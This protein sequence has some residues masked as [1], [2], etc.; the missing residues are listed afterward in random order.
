MVPE[1]LELPPTRAF[2]YHGFLDFAGGSG[3]DSATLAIAHKQGN[4]SGI[5]VLDAVR[6][7]RPPFSPE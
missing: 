3:G 4:E 6:E 5:G 7:V 1:R 2:R